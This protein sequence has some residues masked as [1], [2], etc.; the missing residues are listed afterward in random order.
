MTMTLQILL[1]LFLL[2]ISSV[3][4]VQLFQKWSLNFAGLRTKGEELISNKL[5]RYIF[6]QPF[7]TLL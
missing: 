2:V 3:Y 5:H 6:A 7:L 4:V 1:L